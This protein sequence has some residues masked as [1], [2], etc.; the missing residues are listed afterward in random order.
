M[1]FYCQVVC[2]LHIAIPRGFLGLGHVV[3]NLLYHVL[4]PGGELLARN[5]LKV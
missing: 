4:L 1:G 5:I 3:V 2:A